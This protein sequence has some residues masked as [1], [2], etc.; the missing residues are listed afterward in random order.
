MMTLLIRGLDLPGR[1]MDVYLRPLIDE[2]KMLWETGV[3]TYDCVSKER[4]NIRAAFMWTVNDFPMYGYL[5]GWSTSGYKACLTCNED[6]TSVRLRD[7]L[8]SIG[9]RRFLP[10]DHPWRK[11]HDFDGKSKNR[12]VQTVS[13]G[14]DCL[15]QLENIPS[16]FG[17]VRGKK[18]KNEIH[19][20]RTGQSGVYF[21][22]FLTGISCCCAITLTSCM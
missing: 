16:E 6:T 1:D 10:T 17:K 7:K 22:N 18:K 2:L 15:R 11:S 8:S 5:S 13:T 4:F 12:A 9:H 19:V 20:T 14:E 3:E 21:L